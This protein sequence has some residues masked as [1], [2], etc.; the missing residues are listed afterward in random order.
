MSKINSSSPKT[1]QKKILFLAID[2]TRPDALMVADSPFFHDFIKN[3][4]L[5]YSLYGD[6]IPTTFSAPSWVSILTGVPETT[7]KIMKNQTIE[8][9]T[10]FELPTTFFDF[11]KKPSHE[12]TG[13]A[14]VSDWHGMKNLQEK[15]PVPT[16]FFHGEGS[17]KN[18]SRAALN[19]LEFLQQRETSD[20]V[21]LYLV[22]VD[23]EGHRSGFAPHNPRYLNAISKM[24]SQVGKLFKEIERRRKDYHEDWLVVITTDHGGTEYKHLPSDLKS[25]F[26]KEYPDYAKPGIHGFAIK[27]H[28]NIFIFFQHP[29]LQA[30]E[31]T[32]PPTSLDIVPTILSFFGVSKPPH[33]QGQSLWH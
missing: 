1:L 13:R 10:Q 29:S 11:L 28:Q 2:G 9:N 16:D 3:P 23:E 33:L 17:E 20:L 31:I 15:I 27:P 18:D 19:T 24:D 8:Q 22:N 6:S 12:F 32:P 21:F 5:L 7:H 4:H 14:F 30:K 26:E 25:R